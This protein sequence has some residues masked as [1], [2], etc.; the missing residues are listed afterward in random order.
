MKN[1]RMNPIFLLLLVIV[2]LLCACSAK[3]PCG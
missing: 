3:K 1:R 2:L